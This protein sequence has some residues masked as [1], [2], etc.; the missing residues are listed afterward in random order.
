MIVTTEIRTSNFDLSKLSEDNDLTNGQIFLK[1]QSNLY[2]NM[3]Q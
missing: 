1:V 3:S 2:S